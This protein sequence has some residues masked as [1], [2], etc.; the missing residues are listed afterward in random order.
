MACIKKL[1]IHDEY[2]GKDFFKIRSCI[3]IMQMISKSTQ[4][5]S[6]KVLQLINNYKVYTL[7]NIT[8]RHLQCKTMFIIQQKS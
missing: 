6:I 8:C 3:E 5:I 7:G 4:F 2:Y 1:F